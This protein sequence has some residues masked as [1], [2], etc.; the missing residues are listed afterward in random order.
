MVITEMYGVD[1]FSYRQ[2]QVLKNNEGYFVALYEHG[3]WVR[4]VEVYSH[5][6]HY[7]ED[8][9]ENWTLGVIAE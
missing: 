8:V 2:A 1:D 4:D 9:A 5:S 7:A 3:K 6:L